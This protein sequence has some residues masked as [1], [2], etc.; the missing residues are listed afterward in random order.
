MLAE[1]VALALA[2]G[3]RIVDPLAAEAGCRD[4]GVGRDQWFAAARALEDAGLVALQTA[5]P[6][7]VV[8]LAA[9]NIGILH[10]LEATNFDLDGTRQRLAGVLQKTEL[11]RP[12][13][14][15]EGAD[16]PALLVECLLDGWVDQRLVVYSLAPGRR[17][18]IHQFRLDA[19][20]GSP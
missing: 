17:F 20:P 5:P 14:L 16:A 6:S 1:V 12:V 11:N 15:A 10:H 18:R 4:R 7:Q 2:T 3:R 19:R 9:T 8:L 13:D